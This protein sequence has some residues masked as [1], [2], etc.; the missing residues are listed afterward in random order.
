MAV[1]AVQTIDITQALASLLADVDGLRIEYYVA[2]KSR[3]PVAVFGLPSIDFQ[4]PDAG[5]CYATFE[6]P[7]L[8]ITARNNDREAQHELSRLVC[9]VANALNA[10]SPPGIFSIDLL[11]ARPSVATVSG[12]ELP[13]Y[14]LRV[15]VR[16]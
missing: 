3:P 7:I 5:F 4:D 15:R 1:T 13:A 11:D 16:A 8:I 2:D 12:Q 6:C 14:Q 9:D 10:G